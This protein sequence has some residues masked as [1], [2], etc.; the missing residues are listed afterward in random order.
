MAITETEMFVFLF[1]RALRREKSPNI[2]VFWSMKL[3]GLINLP[4]Q[5]LQPT[6]KQMDW[7]FDFQEYHPHI[8]FTEKV[9]LKRY[10]HVKMSYSKKILHSLRHSLLDNAPN[11]LV[12]CVIQKRC[13]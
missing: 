9:Q 7:L 1:F 2:N 4:I 13:G 8:I 6:I 12:G 11:Y 3:P 10:S 5:A